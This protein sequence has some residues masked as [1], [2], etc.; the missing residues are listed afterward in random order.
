MNPNDH[1]GEHLLLQYLLGK[2]AE[3]DR[4][5]IDRWLS[6]SEQNRRYLD[7]LEAVWL[8]TGK[9]SP[10][11]VAV[12]AA[13]A[14]KRLSTRVD[15][16]EEEQKTGAETGIIRMQV[17]RWIAGIAATVVIAIGI[18]WLADRLIQ[19]PVMVTVTS[20]NEVMKDSLPDGSLITLNKNTTLTYPEKFGK[21]ERTVSLSGEAFFNVQSGRK[22]F[23]V[24]AGNGNIR[25]MGTTFNVKSYPGETTEVTVNT[26]KVMF[27]GIH[28]QTGDTSWV[29]LTE[30]MKGILNPGSHTPEITTESAPDEQ[31]WMNRRLDF[32][33]TSLREV[34]EA[35]AK[36]YDVTIHAGNPQ[37]LSCHLTAIFENDP[38]G[39]ILE[40]IAESFNLTL[41]SENNIYEFNGN[42]CS[43]QNH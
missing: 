20:T 43:G 7:R 37:I 10:P 35:L 17:V 15:R 21:K 18:L 42:G 27:F 38:A 11:P 34:F 26:G 33:Q 3:E 13:M 29:I 2:A 36:Y 6:K 41:T 24:E 22:P 14:W 40:V 5:Q 32:R 8:E 16:Y 25:V 4:L 1:I 31:F 12:D 28:P 19:P 30:G 23:I 39:Q 9:L